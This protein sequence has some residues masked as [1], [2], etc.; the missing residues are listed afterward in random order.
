MRAL[1]P[2][3]TLSL[4]AACGPAVESAY[5]GAPPPAPAERS[6]LPRIYTHT[7]PPCAFEEIGRVRVTP[8]DGFQGLPSLVAAMRRRA[9]EMGGDA[10]VGFTETSQGASTTVYPIVEGVAYASTSPNSSYFGTVVRYTDAACAAAQA[11]AP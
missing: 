6:A 2:V 9:G 11:S 10:I 7:E 3:L 1:A 4:L 8:R 5:F